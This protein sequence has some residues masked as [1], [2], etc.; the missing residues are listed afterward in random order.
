MSSKVF[1]E[2]T[3]RELESSFLRHELPN[4]ESTVLELSGALEKLA[5]Q[6][7]LIQGENSI[8]AVNGLALSAL[9]LLYVLSAPSD[10]CT[11]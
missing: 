3:I 5:G 11:L 6:S 9:D 8:T 7:D 4:L 2:E 1:S 10:V